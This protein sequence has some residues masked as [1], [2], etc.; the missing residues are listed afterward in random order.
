MKFEATK[1]LLY[2]ITID[3]MFKRICLTVLCAI[4]ISTICY[5]QNRPSLTIIDRSDQALGITAQTRIKLKSIKNRRLNIALFAVDRRSQ[6]D[7]GNSDIIMIISVNQETGEIKMA[8]IMRD[9]YVSIDGHGMDKINAAYALGGPQLAIKTINKNFGT[10]ISDFINV[11]FFT[12]AKIIDAIGGLNIDIKPAEVR[13]L[14]NYLEEIAIYENAATIPISKS[15]AQTL[16]GRQTVAYTRIRDVGNGDYERTER[17]R[18]I[19]IQLF[20]KMKKSGQELV[21]TFTKEIIP[22]LETSMNKI[23][24]L[25]FSGSIL[26]ANN[27]SIKQARF[28]LD[29][30]GRG[31]KINNI[32][33][34]VTDLNA[35]KNSLYKFFYS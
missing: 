1:T 11:D 12:A 21:P 9:T 5:G 25:N 7:A 30:Q 4:L 2:L 26:Y 3:N 13:S 22:N 31:K 35:V 8:S 34:L 14:N 20:N 29:T 16:S 18:H 19:L 15:G 23:S 28:P 24:L 6:N 17:Q 27:K 32:W 33:Y 10:D